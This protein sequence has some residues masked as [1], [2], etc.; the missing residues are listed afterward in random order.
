MAIELASRTLWV[1]FGRRLG[2]DENVVCETENRKKT[3]HSSET[4]I[5]V[6]VYI[7][8]YECIKTA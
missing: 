7:Q 8:I 1:A 2:G 5:H 6:F 4:L 3:H